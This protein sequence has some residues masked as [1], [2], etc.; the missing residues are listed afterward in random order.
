[1]SKCE[2]STYESF[3][4]AAPTDDVERQ[5]PTPES[6]LAPTWRN[7]ERLHKRVLAASDEA[8]ADRLDDELADLIAR[9]IYEGTERDARKALAYIVAEC[10]DVLGM[11]RT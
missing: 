3:D 10:A 9:T 8:E 4:H 6:S 7:I 1:M 5:S 2:H 11:P